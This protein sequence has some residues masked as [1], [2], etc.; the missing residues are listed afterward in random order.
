MDVCTRN[1][2]WGSHLVPGMVHG[3]DGGASTPAGE[4][5]GRI[6]NCADRAAQP[7]RQDRS[8]PVRKAGLGVDG[9]ACAGRD[10]ISRKTRRLLHS[11]SPGS[12]DRRDGGGLCVWHRTAQA[13][14]GKAARDVRR[15][16]DGDSVVR[17][18][19]RYRT[20]RQSTGGAGVRYPILRGPVAALSEFDLDRDFVFQRGE[21]SAIAALSADDARPVAGVL[22][23]AGS[24]DAGRTAQPIGTLDP[25]VRP[26]SDVFLRLAYLRDPL[27]NPGGGEAVS[28]ADVAAVAR[29]VLGRAAG[30]GLWP[31]FALYLCYVGAD[32]GVALRAVRV[33]RRVES[34]A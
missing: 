2:L 4:V 11:L 30:A 33:V 13:G 12:V 9:S 20:V 18:A 24:R 22:G 29:S 25:G 5:A 3:A 6:R 26:G 16:G 34:A 21:I 10:S 32:G 17:R 7:Y 28:S 31:R 14:G 1:E 23:V 8:C 15:W 27:I 19:A